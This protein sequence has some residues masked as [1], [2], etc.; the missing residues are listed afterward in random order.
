MCNSNLAV[1]EL[2]DNSFTLLADITDA[3]ELCLTVA[4]EKAAANTLDHS[5]SRASTR[6]AAVLNVPEDAHWRDVLW[7]T[8]LWRTILLSSLAKAVL[9]HEHQTI[10][11]GPAAIT[12]GDGDRSSLGNRNIG[13]HVD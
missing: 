2:L 7:T 11:R 4:L 8:A 9:W 3:N 12:N 6:H 5:S 1:V 10:R 13:P